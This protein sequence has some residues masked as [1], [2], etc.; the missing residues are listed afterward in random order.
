[1]AEDRYIA[2]VPCWVDCAQPDPEAA[3]A[4][5]GGLFGWTFEERGPGYHVASLPSGDVGAIGTPGEVSGPPAWTT[6]VWVADADE[7]VA[8][9]RAAGGGVL[10]EPMDVGPAGRTAAVAD[11]AGATFR[12]WQAGTNRG[13]TAVNEPGSVNFNTLHTR[14]LHGAAG[15]YDA[16]FG[17]ELLQDMFWGLAP[18]G[19]FLERRT[20]GLRDRMAQMGAPER[21]EDTVA[22]VE[23][24]ADDDT[25]PYWGVTFAV[26]DADATAARAAELGGTVTVAPFDAPWVRMT[27]ITDPQGAS[28]VAGQFVPPETAD[29][30]QAAGSSAA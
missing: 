1:M 20:P 3:K 17:W 29:A 16:V 6:Y 10:N 5:Y 11:R 12:V 7:T 13:A 24:L 9:V 4:F 23:R 26:A 22:A 18:Y 15:F 25:Q 21:F 30:G 2:G 14:D 19:D 8:K 27:V 28:L